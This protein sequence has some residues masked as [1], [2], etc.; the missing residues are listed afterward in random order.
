MDKPAIIRLA[1]RNGVSIDL[2][3]H[4][5]DGDQV[6]HGSG[7]HRWNN[8]DFTLQDYPFLDRYFKVYEY[9]EYLKRRAEIC[10]KAG[11]GKTLPTLGYGLLLFGKLFW[12]LL[13]DGSLVS[14]GGVYAKYFFTRNL[15][16]RR[17]IIGFAQFMNRCVVH[18][19][20][21]KF[22]R[23]AIEGRLRTY[24]SG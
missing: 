6:W 20:F 19:H 8:A 9:P 12:T 3:I 11:E 4:F 5:C 2:F 18:W 10:T 15:K 21:Y 14:V 22:T 24:N 16:Y 1:H 7:V 17:D 13:R 23:N